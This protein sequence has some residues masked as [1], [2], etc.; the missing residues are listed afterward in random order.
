MLRSTVLTLQDWTTFE[1]L[2]S[3]GKPRGPDGSGFI[4]TRIGLICIH[5][6][7]I[8][9]VEHGSQPFG[10]EDHQISNVGNVEIHNPPKFVR[11]FERRRH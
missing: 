6:L 7:S 3:Q 8:T 1:S 5:R 11:D 4:Q 2:S 10:S 9:D